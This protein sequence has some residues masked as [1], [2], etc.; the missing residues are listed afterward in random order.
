M[1][2]LA[3]TCVPS[4]FTLMGR[5]M[6]DRVRRSSLTSQ[7]TQQSTATTARADGGAMQLRHASSSFRLAA[8][9][10]VSAV[11]P[12]AAAAALTA[13]TGVS[14]ASPGVGGPDPR[15]VMLEPGDVVLAVDGVTV[16]GQTL[17]HV[18]R[19]IASR[20]QATGVWVTVARPIG[21]MVTAVPTPPSPCSPAEHG[22]TVSLHAAAA[23]GGVIS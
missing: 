15:V 9:K 4:P 21:R 19:K 22:D 6:V 18:A 2:A 3:S 5:R 16:E 20:A 23:K 17:A 7:T 13:A 12:A 8:G 10:P 11:D 1:D 14:L